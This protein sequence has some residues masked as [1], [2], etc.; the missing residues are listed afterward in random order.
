VLLQNEIFFNPTVIALEISLI[1]AGILPN[2]WTAKLLGIKS[3]PGYTELKPETEENYGSLIT[4]GPFSV[5]RHPS[6]WA[7]S[8][9]MW[10]RS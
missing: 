10:A 4:S 5:V 9:I 7:H 8:L 6:Y 3:T 2:S 1:I